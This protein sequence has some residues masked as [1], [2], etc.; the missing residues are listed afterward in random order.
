[1]IEVVGLLLAILGI[2][3]AFETPRRKLVD[4]FGGNA[5][6]PPANQ[7]PAPLNIAHGPVAAI[8]GATQSGR[9]PLFISEPFLSLHE[10]KE[11]SRQTG[12]PLF[13]VIY[14]E[15]HPSRSKL[16]YSLGCFLDYFATKKLLDQHFVC[17][18]L[19]A[20]ADGTREYV[21]DDDPLENA[22]L[23]VTSAAGEVLRREGV[24]ANPDEGLK[25]VR[26]II[27]QL[28]DA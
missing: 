11:E 21:P 3:F 5:K 19:P 22:L 12:K 13:L 26:S 18:L 6:T 15:E 27:A 2:V 28:T 25:R 17:A 4:I 9:S 24:Y 10:A 1:M 16:D 14:D 23:V 20:S 8:S 7:T